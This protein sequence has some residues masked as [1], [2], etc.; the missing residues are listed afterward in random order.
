M[1]LSRS[2]A[3]KSHCR[4]CSGDDNGNR[5]VQ[6]C[7]VTHCYLFPFRRGRPNK[8]EIETHLQARA[9]IDERNKLMRQKLKKEE[10]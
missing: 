8:R 4:E 9:N 2:D 10:R 3:V 1:N 7:T 6:L 5:S